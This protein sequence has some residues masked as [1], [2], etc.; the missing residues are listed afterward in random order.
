MSNTNEIVLFQP[1]ETV[2]LEVL[3]DEDTV[4][5]TQA[6]MVELFQTSKTNVNEHIKHIFDEGELI[7]NVVVRNFRTTTRH[8]AIS[9]KTQTRS[10]N[11]YNLDVIISVGYRVKSQRGTQF[12]IWA[13]GVLKDYLLRGYA[14]NQR[15]E[16][17][18]R[19]LNEVESKVDF[20]VR[21]TLPPIEGVFYQGQIFD[22]YEFASKL[23]KTAKNRIVLLDNYIDESVLM[24]LSKR[25]TKVT[26]EIYTRR[27]SRQLQLDLT[28][29]NAQYAPI[30]IRVSNAF[31]DRFLIIDNTV[32]HIGASLKDLG[33]TMFAFSKMHIT[34]AELLK[35]IQWSD[36]L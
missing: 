33:K 26:A 21:T 30:T 36:T 14:V 13:S 17:I 34:A 9:G 11:Y 1:D 7:K 23:I 16:R 32:Y 31:H 19:K 29:H 35:N 20:F 8:G 10:V 6:Q 22:A 15:M 27:I 4:W 28:K 18:E 2:H 3:L 24:L 12:R 5:L 25:N